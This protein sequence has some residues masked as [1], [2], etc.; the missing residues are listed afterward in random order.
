MALI[1]NV[2][3]SAATTDASDLTSPPYGA[4]FISTASCAKLERL[5]PLSVAVSLKTYDAPSLRSQR[6]HAREYSVSGESGAGGSPNSGR[7]RAAA[8]EGCR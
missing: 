8:P 5:V 1:V 4:R 2:E 6:R 7:G 3:V